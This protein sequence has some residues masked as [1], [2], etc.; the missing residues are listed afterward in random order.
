MNPV[1]SQFFASPYWIFQYTCFSVT[2]N[3]YFD[4]YNDIL[5][6][7]KIWHLNLLIPAGT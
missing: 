7:W 6:L 4:G 3:I 2:V 1:T 5:G